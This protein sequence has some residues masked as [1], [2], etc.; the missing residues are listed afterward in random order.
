MFN[1]NYLHDAANESD[2][3]RVVLWLDMKRKMPPILNAINSFLLGTGHVSPT[4]YN[5]RQRAEKYALH[6]AKE[7]GLH[8]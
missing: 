2:Q 3:V 8:P 5:I 6:L 4:L 7:R 1:D